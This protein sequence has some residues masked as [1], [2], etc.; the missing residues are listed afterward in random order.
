MKIYSYFVLMLITIGFTPN[1]LF[2]QDYNYHSPLDIPLIL[3][4]NFGEL[5]RNHF[6]TGLDIKTQGTTGKNVYRWF[7]KYSYKIKV[8]KQKNVFTNC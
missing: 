4:G 5:R 3:S 8:N 7:R 1:N 6:H 2:S